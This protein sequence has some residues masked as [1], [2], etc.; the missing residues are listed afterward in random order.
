[1]QLHFDRGF[2]PTVP[3]GP[4]GTEHIVSGWLFHPSKRAHALSVV[5]GDQVHRVHYPHDLRLDVASVFAAADPAGESLLSGFYGTIPLSPELAGRSLPASLRIDWSDGSS[6]THAIGHT[7]FLEEP[8]G[9]NPGPDTRVPRARLVICLATYK[10]DPDALARQIDSIVNQTVED[11]VCIVN[12]DGS[13]PDL[14]ERIQAICGRDARFH[15]SRNARNLGF[16]RN[17]EMALW[18]ARNV[19]ASFVALSDQDDFWYP[20][21]LERCLAA[22]DNEHA[23][24]YCDMKLARPSGEILSD[25]YWFNRRNNHT[26]ADV[27]FL[28]NTVT[29]AA[30]VFRAGLL[31]KIL[32]FPDPIGDCFHD[33]WIGCCALASG[34][35]AYLDEPLYEYVQHGG[36]VIGHCSFDEHPWLTSFRSAARALRS[37][38][39]I[40]AVVRQAVFQ[41]L[42]VYVYEYRRL[43]LF[44]RILG[45]RFP[46]MPARRR[47]AFHLTDGSWASVCRLFAA[48]FRYMLTRATTGDAE[49]RLAFGYLTAKA[50]GWFVNL[51][52]R[53]LIRRIRNAQAAQASSG[54]RVV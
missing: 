8:E 47:R 9:V 5:L 50:T 14:Y 11:W 49:T 35:L 15:V 12:D 40:K 4:A 33:H 31:E 42:A 21:K 52:R 23:L 32:P 37:G 24:A 45:S 39:S 10:P 3:V 25:T 26:D 38:S 46:G 22:L 30:S 27:I 54:P 41:S 20:R 18:K 43:E 36:N 19:G 53:W 13:P 44:G 34:R 2:P 1:L 16:Y 6:D 7:T 29:G 51:G 48:H 28:A 17:Y